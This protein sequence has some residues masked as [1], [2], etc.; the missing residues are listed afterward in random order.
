[1]D[2]ERTKTSLYD[3]EIDDDN[4]KSPGVKKRN[5]NELNL[6]ALQNKTGSTS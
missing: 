2:D 5:K 1:M 4:N 3:D 6:G